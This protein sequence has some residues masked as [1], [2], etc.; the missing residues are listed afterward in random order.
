MHIIKEQMY[1]RK[2]ECTVGGEEFSEHS[3]MELCFH[4]PHIFTF[5]PLPVP[6]SNCRLFSQ[7]YMFRQ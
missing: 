6:V 5:C 7:S 2:G 3:G 1:K 4:A